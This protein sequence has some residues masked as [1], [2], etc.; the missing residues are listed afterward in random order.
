MVRSV[1]ITFQ[2]FSIIATGHI[3]VVAVVAAVVAVV[4]ADV[5]ATVVAAVVAVVP[6]IKSFLV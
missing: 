1:L 2:T 3:A 6:M 5:V 4:V